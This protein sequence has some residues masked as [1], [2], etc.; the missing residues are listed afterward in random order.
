MY[1]YDPLLV[2]IELEQGNL[3]FAATLLTNVG[4]YIEAADLYKRMGDEA[5]AARCLFTTLH[6]SLAFTELPEN[7]DKKMEPLG[8]S[9]HD[10]IN[11]GALKFVL[12]RL[13]VQVR[14]PGR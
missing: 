5:Q 4:R 3:P 14:V 2:E 1:G 9:D 10:N 7:L 12:Q 6:L 8:S 13:A 11:Y